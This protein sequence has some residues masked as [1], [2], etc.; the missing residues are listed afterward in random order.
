MNRNKWHLLGKVTALFLTASLMSCG[1]QDAPSQTETKDQIKAQVVDGIDIPAHSYPFLIV[2]GTD[3]APCG[4]AIINREWVMTAE[5]CAFR[6]GKVTAGE[7]DKTKN[8][9]TEQIRRTTK[10]FQRPG[11]DFAIMK[12]D[13]PL[14]FN[15]YVKPIELGAPPNRHTTYG[16]AGWGMTSP[17]GAQNSRPNTPKAYVGTVVPASI[18]GAVKEEVCI[19]GM[20]FQPGDKPQACHGDSGSPLFYAR[21]GK[22]YAAGV[23]QDKAHTATS[24][25]GDGLTLYAPMNKAWVEKVMAEN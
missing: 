3:G 25:C 17:N 18:C 19:Q 7:H 2:F 24:E 5:H 4:G 9:G 10:V 16:I 13:R 20:P 1:N 11:A 22:F 12:L 8:E 23:V 14:D 15:Q 21:N 6:D